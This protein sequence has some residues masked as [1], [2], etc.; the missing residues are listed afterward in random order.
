MLVSSEAVA[1]L[2]AHAHDDI[3]MMMSSPALQA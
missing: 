1:A 2:M 3:H